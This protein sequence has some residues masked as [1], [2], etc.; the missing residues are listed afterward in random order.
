MN[1][2][3]ILI[4]SDNAKRLVE[5]YTKIL[6]E[7]GM[8]EGDSAGWQLGTGSVNIGPHDQVTGPNAQ[9][10][11]I[12]WNSRARTSMAIFDRLKARSH[13]VREPYRL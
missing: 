11:R 5:Y 10:G 4:G 6:G 13:R 9:P 7:P 3:S 12:I 2:N 1:L 8:V